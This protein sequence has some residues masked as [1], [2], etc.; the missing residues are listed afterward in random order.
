MSDIS[1]TPAPQ[2]AG[3]HG[4]VAPQPGRGLRIALAISVALNLG[5]AGMV[6]GTMMRNHSDGGR[7]DQVRELGFGPF[8]E[9]LSREDRRALRQSFLAKSPGAGQIKH[10]RR[11]NALA[12]LD[13]LRATPFVPENLIGVMQAQQQRTARQ[14]DLGQTVLRDFL[15][16][17]SPAERAAFAGRLE[18]RLRPRQG[19]LDKPEQADA[20]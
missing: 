5:I 3:L 18:D 19:G 17:M 15:I 13:A 2:R 1:P 20:P 10:Q 4:P 11:D 9:A 8:I 16:A 6:A 7:T 14:L 12:V